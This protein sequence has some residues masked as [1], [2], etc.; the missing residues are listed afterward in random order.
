MASNLP[1][2][3]NEQIEL[4]EY[5]KTMFYIQLTRFHPKSLHRSL[6]V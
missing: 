5:S 2:N 6:F 1:K 4:V 3:T